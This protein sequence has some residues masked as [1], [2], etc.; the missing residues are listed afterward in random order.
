ME[1]RPLTVMIGANGVGKTSVL[2][3]F[4]LLASAAQ[5]KLKDTISKFG[6]IEDI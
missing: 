1:M 6:G 3:V 4:G 2:E 5:G